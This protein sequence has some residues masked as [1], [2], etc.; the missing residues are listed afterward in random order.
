MLSCPAVICLKG[1]NT[2]APTALYGAE[3][4]APVSLVNNH[5][6]NNNNFFI[7][8]GLLESHTPTSR[9]PRA[10]WKAWADCLSVESHPFFCLFFSFAATVF[11]FRELRRKASQAVPYG[12]YETDQYNVNNLTLYVS[13]RISLVAFETIPGWILSYIKL[14]LNK[15]KVKSFSNRGYYTNVFMFYSEHE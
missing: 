2:K 12:Y 1:S 3:P 9:F 11:R 4:V 8:A 6:N 15:R 5:N 7:L 14:N 10:R 13:I